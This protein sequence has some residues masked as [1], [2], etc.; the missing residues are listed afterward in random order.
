[1]VELLFQEMPKSMPITA[2]ATHQNI[3]TIENTY[4]IPDQNVAVFV[5]GQGENVIEHLSRARAN[6]AVNDCADRP[7]IVLPISK[8]VSDLHMLD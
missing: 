7:R 5:L 3:P 8:L 1:M 4:N 2:T 6:R